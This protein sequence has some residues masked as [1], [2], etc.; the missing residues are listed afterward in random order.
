VKITSIE[1]VALLDPGKASETV[2]HVLT[3]EGLSGLGQAESPSFV[4]E[5]I[6]RNDGGL[7]ALLRCEDSLPVERYWQKT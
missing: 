3:D 1:T 5:A 2:V 7:E 4:I 6:I